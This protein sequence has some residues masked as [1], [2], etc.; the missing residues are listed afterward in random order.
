MCHGKIKRMNQSLKYL[1][2]NLRQGW[3]LAVVL[4]SLA[5]FMVSWL[6]GYSSDSS[7][8]QRVLEDLVNL[9]GPLKAL[10]PLWLTALIFFNNSLKAIATMFSGLALGLGPL[11]FLIVNGFL[12]GIVVNGVS[13]QHGALVSILSLLPHGILEFP[14]IILSAALGLHLGMVVLKKI[15]G[16]ES[17]IKSEIK[18]SLFFFAAII[19]PALFVA[20]FI[21]VFVTPILAEGFL[22]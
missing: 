1:L 9:L 4:V 12:L 6:A 20:A 16:K 17:H 22:R 14:S 8:S 3:L 19:L 21:E 2:I 11:V 13:L 15:I 5:I 18:L 10:N 7:E